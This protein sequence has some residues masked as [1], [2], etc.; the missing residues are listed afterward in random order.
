MPEIAN[1][2]QCQRQ[3]RVPD[4]LLGQSVKC[5]SCGT[6]FQ[7]TMQAAPSPPPRWQ[8]AGDPISEQPRPSRPAE[9]PPAAGPP[10]RQP[11]WDRGQGYYGDR[12]PGY[13]GDSG[14]GYMRRDWKPHNGATILTLGILS[15]V[16]C[17]PILGPIAWIMGNND[18]AQIRAGQM[19]PSGEGITQAGRICGMIASILAIV[20][21][22]FWIMWIFMVAG[23]ANL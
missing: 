7:A 22:V 20:G 18:L 10:Y 14:Q 15:L 17:G 21:C 1:C 9:P 2:P 6:T 11:D 4:N 16:L 19:D 8:E 3:L 5:P 12:G 13:Y 23:M